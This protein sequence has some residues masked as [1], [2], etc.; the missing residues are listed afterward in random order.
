MK[1]QRTTRRSPSLPLLLLIAGGCAGDPPDEGL[2]PLR[3]TSAA[4]HERLAEVAL[5][6][7]DY[8]KAGQ[9][10]RESLRVESARPRAARVLAEAMLRA[11]RPQDALDA[12]ERAVSLDPEDAVAWWLLGECAGAAGNPERSRLA[13][14]LAAGLGH[15]EARLALARAALDRGDHDEADA[16]LEHCRDRAA[17]IAL[18]IAADLE[19]GDTAGAFARIEAESAREPNDPALLAMRDRLRVVAGESSAREPGGTNG[20]SRL[21]GIERRLLDA[22]ASM[23]AGDPGNAVAEYRGLL[24]DEPLDPAIRSAL[25]EALLES[26]DLEGA[27]AA[28]HSA[29]ELD[30]SDQVAMLGLARVHLAARDFAAAKAV[31]ERAFAADPRHAPTLALLVAACHAGGDAELARA[32]AD[33]LRRLDPG[34]PLDLACRGLLA[35]GPPPG[36]GDRTEVAR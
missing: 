34:G 21:R 18:L 1:S 8:A 23:R 31:L 13:F 26:G 4:V 5:A 36:A 30:A 3:E 35:G 28:F 29:S 16:L 32:R 14:E 9:S 11:G 19:R 20:P 22:A 15:D 7:G 6:R 24:R 12:A 2:A 25:G 33:E 27:A 17:A 10:A